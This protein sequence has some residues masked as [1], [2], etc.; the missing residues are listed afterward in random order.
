MNNVWTSALRSAVANRSRFALTI[1]AVALS[2]GFLTATLILSD[3]LTGTAADDIAAANESIDYVVTGETIFAGD[4]GPGDAAV[5]AELAPEV[6]AQLLADPAI[7]DAVGVATGFAKLVDDGVA[8]GDGVAADV[9]RAWAT[10][11]V[12]NPF[13]LTRGE[14]PAGIGEVVIDD[15]LANQ[16]D[17]SVG[18]AVEVL[19]A[20][21][22]TEM[23]VSGTAGFGG[24]DA[25]PLQRTILFSE[26]GA[27]ALLEIDGFGEVLI[28]STADPAAVAAVVRSAD[29]TALTSTGAEAIALAQ[30]AVASPFTFLSVFLLTFAG[31]ATV[32]GSTIIY[33][34]FVIAMAQR[35]RELA[36]MRAIGATR[37]MVL[38][39]VMAEAL[40]ISFVATAVGLSLGLVGVGGVRSL[41]G[42]LGVPILAGSTV[43]TGQTIVLASAVGV[44][45][46][47]AS[48]WFPARRA[49]AAA[50]IEALREAA[51]ETTV[52]GRWR[53]VSGSALLI[54]GIG[55]AIVAA[56]A[57]NALALVGG[58]LVVPGLIL[59]GPAI[60]TVA[61]RVVRA[62]LERL[63]GSRGVIASNNLDR[64][65]KRSSSTSLGLTIGVAMVGFFAV[66]AS[67]LTASFTSSLD[68][69][70]TADQV[71]ASVNPE[72]STIDPT[73]IARVRA[74]PEVEVASAISVV[75]GG[76]EGTEA[77]VGGIDQQASE[78]FDF[79]VA[80]GSL[81]AL[82]DGGVAVW[83]GTETATP[84]LGQE[85]TLSLPSGDLTVPVV[86]VF[87]NSLAGF[88]PPTHLLDQS[89]LG[90][91]EP[92]VL[93]NVLFVA[94]SDDAGAVDALR[95]V[96]A[97]TPGSLL[98]TADDYVA[99]ASA[100]VDSIRN[101]VFA[102]LGLTVVIAV[103]GVANT[104][105]LSVSER[106]REIGLLWAIG[107]TQRDVRRII[108]WEAAVLA[109]VGTSI[110]LAIGVGG[111]WALIA[112]VGGGEV[113]GVAIPWSQLAVLGG[114]ALA[115]AVVSA[116]APAWRISQR[117]TL[118]ALAG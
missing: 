44:L 27:S 28:E 64:N 15:G 5:R 84:A 9:G 103:V 36:L 92:G 2:V 26:A 23:V 85:V 22:V 50:P 82:A 32:V 104:T 19:T 57:E 3:S 8:V 16:G 43:V 88:D 41:M 4:G 20:T 58:A 21:G 45:V 18:D 34:T 116:A 51:V 25:A 70:L 66:L 99:N 53:L 37:R 14:A 69:Q 35:K 112:A 97:A 68:E 110:G 111:A 117:P 94:L 108:R 76:I 118:S 74:V 40:V 100:E 80:T 33:N 86:A 71:V 13:T 72:W 67:S 1:V 98:Q 93:D 31:L 61:S 56:T 59:A 11:P 60:V 109:L 65:P 29:D 89:V 87:D 38:Q 101:L 106:V 79:G 62:P 63:L 114:G 49:S 47:M 30:D 17:L 73:L 24:A 10:N 52:A 12:L 91:A 78:L 90:A 107:S 102:M 39:V 77:V 42:A 75:D 113:T 96:V 105:T 115:A 55:A 83:S 95:D 81:D 54:A 48:A 7:D 6:P 46:T